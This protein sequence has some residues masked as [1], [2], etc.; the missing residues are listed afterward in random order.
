MK[1]YT[2]ILVPVDFN[3]PSLKA[4]QYASQ[5]A[6]SQNGEIILMNVIETPGMLM[7]FFSSGD[8]LVKITNQ[9]KDKLLE[10]ANLLQKNWPNVKFGTRVERGKPYIKILEEA[11]QSE[12][13]MVVLGENH[14][15]KE[16]DT[17]LGTT[18]YHV[19]LKSTVP[20]LTVKG[21][22]VKV[23]NKIVLP[24]DLTRD[25]DKNLKAALMYGKNY[26]SEIHLVSALIGGIRISESRIY[27][28]LK[29]AEKVLN[30]N[31]IRTQVKVFEISKVPPFMRVLEYAEEIE[32]DMIIVMTHQEGFTYDN[33]IGAFAHH[34]INLSKVPVLSLTASATNNDIDHY[35]KTIVDPI[36]LFRK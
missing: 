35:F 5:L 11:K 23:K 27:K 15:C 34:I 29:D 25:T 12:I 6:S 36:G 20:V 3:E 10:L 13:K 26:N 32:A 21:T 8:E 9:S 24:L 4:T 31:D 1:D 33:Y 14:D 30:A 22:P 16:P 2:T 28:K 19:T 17:E 7:E 18:V